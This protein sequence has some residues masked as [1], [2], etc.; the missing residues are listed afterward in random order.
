MI[1]S[2]DELKEDAPYV[3]DK[4]TRLCRRRDEVTLGNYLKA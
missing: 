1:H 4:G 2:L 3:T